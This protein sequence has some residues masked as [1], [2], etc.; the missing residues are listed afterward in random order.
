MWSEPYLSNRKTI[1]YTFVYRGL[2]AVLTWVNSVITA[3]YLIH[4]GDRGDFQTTTTYATSGQRFSGGY[5]NY[6]S[7]SLPRRPQ[8]AV[9]IVQMG[10]FVM[11]L[12]SILVWL[13]A[14]AVLWFGHPSTLVMF[15][16]VGMPL[17]F[18]F[19]YASR[20]L[21]A[22]D[23]IKALNRANVS[24]AVA[25]LLIYLAFIAFN[26]HLGEHQRLMWTYK[27]W[28]LSWII[29]V[30]MTLFAV[31]RQLGW[32][33]H[34]KWKWQK[35]EWRSFLGFGTWSSLALLSGYVNLRI[36]FWMLGWLTRKLP[37]GRDVVSIY[38][39]AVTAAEIL[40]TLSQSIST[41]V[42]RRMSASDGQDA[43]IVTESASRQTLITS[44]IVAAGLAILMPFLVLVYGR[45]KYGGSVGPFYILL[46]GLVLKTVSTLIS[47]YF[48]NSKG[49]PF[50]LLIV[51]LLMISF[52]ALI[53]YFIIPRLSMYGASISS[54]IAYFTELSVYV[55]WYHRTSGRRGIDLWR[56]KKGDLLPYLSV[57]QAGLRKLKPSR[58]SG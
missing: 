58:S 10:N 17:T 33:H 47:Q 22:L 18:L 38:G 25:F 7:R 50:T 31:Y 3:R 1:F 53:C 15:S 35:T 39:V 8:D 19:G 4:P 55:F 30:A 40:M 56:L 2:S 26:T 20:L 29:C 41:V 34:L 37:H 6:F 27:I 11:F 28:L 51:N 45:N 46:P 12:L 5:S 14:L 57:V 16:L 49:K 44:I 21:N 52:N 23:N 24:Q 32:G 42:F 9:Q 54:T 13:I 43:G 36:D 48:T